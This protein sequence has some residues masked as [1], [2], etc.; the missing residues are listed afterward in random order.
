MASQMKEADGRMN[1]LDTA[2]AVSGLLSGR[3]LG[4]ARKSG[5]CDDEWPREEKDG[6]LSCRDRTP[7][8]VDMGKTKGCPLLCLLELQRE[9]RKQESGG[10]W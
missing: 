5:S 8:E 1:R 10:Q 2:R 6:E 9:R 4:V 3:N 7:E